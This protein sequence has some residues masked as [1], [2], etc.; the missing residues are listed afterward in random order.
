MTEEYADAL[1][2][3]R[4][5]SRELDFHSWDNFDSE[6]EAIRMIQMLFEA[7]KKMISAPSQHQR[8]QESQRMQ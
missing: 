1:F 2:S 6:T 5:Q 8:N 4:R 3:T 7:E